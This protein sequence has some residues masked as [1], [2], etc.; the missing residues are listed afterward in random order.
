[1]SFINR[2]LR[3]FLVGLILG[4]SAT[5]LLSLPTQKFTRYTAED[6]L[7]AFIVQQMFQ[8]SYGCLWVGTWN[9]LYSFD[10]HDFKRAGENGGIEKI[11]NP[12]ITQMVQHPDGTIWMITYD[13][14]VYR[15]SAYTGQYTQL[16]TVEHHVHTL[17]MMPDGVCWMLTDL[18]ELLM[19]KSAGP[20]EAVQVVDFFQSQSLR[21]PS[22]INNLAYD[23][24]GNHWIMTEEGAYCYQT[25]TK[26]LSL[27]TQASAYE[28]VFTDEYGYFG[29]RGGILYRCNLASMQSDEVR[30]DT[31]SSI[32]RIFRMPDNRLM[33]LTATDGFFF[34]DIITGHSEH[35][36]TRNLPGLGDDV[37]RDAFVDHLGELWLRTNQ[38]GIVH[39]VPATGACRRHI[40]HDDNG[41]PLTEAS[42]EQQVIEDVNHRLWVHPS[43]GGLGWYNRETDQL[44]IFYNPNLTHRWNN[45]SQLLL[46]F[47]DQQG[48]LWFC[49]HINGLEKASFMQY[50]FILENVDSENRGHACNNVRAIHQ[51]QDGRI[52]AGCRDRSIR[53]FSSD[54]QFVGNLCLDG[55]LHKDRHD[56]FYPV[57][58]I[59]QTPDGA[60]WIGTKGDGLFLLRPNGPDSYSIRHFKSSSQ[61]IYSLGSN[62]IYNLHLDHKGRLWIAT[63]ENGVNILDY[64]FDE[65]RFRFYNTHNELGNYP[66]VT[67]SRARCITSDDQDNIFIGTTGGLLVCKED[68]ANYGNLRFKQYV[69]EKGVPSSL[70][71][72]DITGICVT[73]TGRNFVTTFG[74]G[75]CE[76]VPNDKGGYDFTRIKDPTGKRMNDIVYSVV[77]DIHGDI[78]TVEENAVCHIRPDSI[79]E[80]FSD[81]QLPM[82]LA[83]NE[84]VPAKLQ[85]GEL[86]VPS[87]MGAMRFHP[88]SLVHSSFVP[89]ICIRNDSIL[90]PPGEHDFAIQF[91]A[92]DFVLPE[93]IQYAYRLVGFEDEW[94]Y[95]GNHHY[96]N[97]TNLPVGKYIFEVRSTNHSG[98]WV[99]NVRQMMVEV[100]PTFGET[101]FAQVL[102]IFGIILF[103]L[104]VVF[105]VFWILRLHQRMRI[106]ERVT[107]QKLKLY[108]NLSHE[109]RTPLTLI[110]GPL[111]Q[112]RRRKDLPSSLAKQLD[113]VSSNAT[114]MLRTVNQLLDF[115]KIEKGKMHLV[116]QQVDL[117]A[118]VE[119]HVRNFSL[120]SDSMQI[121]LHFDTNLPHL[122]IWADTEKLEH[123]LNNLLGNSFK[124][125][126]PG[127]PIHVSVVKEG[128]KARLVVRDEGIGIAQEQLISI[129][130]RFNSTSAQTP[131]GMASSGI[132]L[133]LTRELVRLHSGDIGVKSQK[134]LGTTFTVTL[135]LGRDHFPAE[136]EF[137][138][139]ADAHSEVSDTLSSIGDSQLG[140]AGAQSAS[141]QH[142]SIAPQTPVAG[143]VSPQGVTDTFGQQ[144]S[145]AGQTANVQSLISGQTTT[146]QDASKLAESASSEAVITADDEQNT[147]LIVEDNQELRA[148]ICSI[149]ES[150]YKVYGAADG[151]EG[152]RLALQIVPDIVISDVMM[153]LMDGF[154]MV[155][156]LRQYPQ[157]CHVSVIM[158]TA[159]SDNDTKL[160]GLGLG[161]DSYITKPFDA[162]YLMARVDNI[163]RK[164]ESLQRYYQQQLIEQGMDVSQISDSVIPEQQTQAPLS[165]DQRFVAKV[166]ADMKAN[167]GNPDYSVDDMASAAN[168]SRSTYGRKFR[169]LMGMVPTDMLRDLRLQRAGELI[170][171]TDLNVSQV[172]YEVGFADPHYFG[173]CFKAYYQM[174]PSEYKA[175][176]QP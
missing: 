70:P 66:L 47:S 41:V 69:P 136:T 21:R 174:T 92:L 139:S 45:T 157:I 46:L 95:V 51:M 39:Y 91:S 121:P 6:G 14:I 31:R 42:T 98:I 23:A 78:W 112:M 10:G 156:Q 114:H 64:D 17:K 40:L 134:G 82:R 90:I 25:A 147:I 81:R 53:V 83:F 171:T 27:I 56:L 63:F 9:G 52:W 60:I 130:E 35:Y 135:P 107:D 176:P 133:S 26:Q 100:Q 76:F 62:A 145:I 116:V 84:G 2:Y 125:S 118:V 170:R 48:N 140:D 55:K 155:Q 28:V 106:E 34:Y 105:S 16:T 143:V 88:D 80:R 131:S 172:A 151:R 68:F 111:E 49:T 20:E 19:G 103:A 102:R 79:I 158:L 89:N 129:F 58:D 1:M 146:E 36:S 175:H 113:I 108:T 72:S 50:P 96:A 138:S 152:L 169:A 30:L 11:D 43:G 44:E 162:T 67:C 24:N 141:D 71:A 115:R 123:I 132:G 148:F 119:Q 99:D 165:S 104:L 86:M 37:M 18:Q 87:L 149:F 137:V 167:L 101:T 65:D 144:S 15:F 110:V 166:V 122:N 94:H 12:R 160:K 29:G 73:S 7:D 126:K 164:R 109:L 75:I 33:L 97:Y 120:L 77:E 153:P 57:Y 32:K 74:G 128:D 142:A 163:L 161:I 127:H 59:I 4:L 124:Y 13:G 85:S 159:L 168:M 8:D 117:V 22:R 93:V 173:K 150:Q 154:Q 61:D 3:I 38:P 5:E 54:Y